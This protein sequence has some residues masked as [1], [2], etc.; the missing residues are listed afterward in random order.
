MSN[1]LLSLSH[2]TK[3]TG[4]Y[5]KD[6]KKGIAFIARYTINKKTKTLIV[7]YE[8]NGMNEYDAFKARL[9]LISTE[10]IAEV[11]SKEKEEEYKYSKLFKQF[12]ESKKPYLAKNT[13]SNYNS[14]YNK[15]IDKDFENKDI[16]EVSSNDL[17][18][19]INLLLKYRR[20]STVEKIVSA[21]K[22]FYIYLQNTGIYKYNPSSNL[23]LPK[24]DNKKYFSMSK[25]NV[26]NFITYIMKMESQFYKTLY[27]ML[28]HGRRVNEVLNLKWDDIDLEKEVYYLHYSKTKTRENQHYFLEKF[29]INELIKLKEQNLNSK[30]VFENPKTKS[31]IAYSSFFRI[32]KRT[33]EDLSLP[34]FNIHGIRHMVAFLIVNN[35]YSLEVTAKVLGHKSIQSTGRY[36]V[37]KMNQAK[38]AYS[39]TFNVNN[40]IN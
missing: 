4:I 6:T 36:A 9:N 10:Q 13:I 38:K 25:R 31:P 39:K 11:L 33:R 34:E 17:Q 7:G 37:L 16:R 40:L 28:L 30:Y 12:I 23:I 1:S 15:Y 35:G 24:Y 8:K 22:K 2:K 5:K 21:F 29:Q 20:P 27:V 3:F 32:H 14:I 26:K 19:Y 18:N